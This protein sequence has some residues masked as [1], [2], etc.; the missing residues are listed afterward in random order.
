[1]KIKPSV[2][3]IWLFLFG[4]IFPIVLSAQNI[5][6]QNIYRVRVNSR[7]VLENGQRTKDF[8]AIGQLISDSLGRVHTE[9]DYDWITHYPNNYRW[10]YFTGQTKYKTDFFINEKLSRIEEYKIDENER[11]SELTVKYVS[12]NDTTF[13]VRVEYKY[14]PNGT[15]LQTKGFN[16]KGKKIYTSNH[17]YNDQGTEILRK[18]KGKS[19]IPPDSILLLSRMPMY[20]SLGRITEELLIT[21]KLSEGKSTKTIKY[22]YDTSGNLIGYIEQDEKGNQ[23]VRKEYTYRKDNRVQQ[24]KVFDAKDNLIDWQAWR[25]EIY[26]TN[27]RRQRVL[28]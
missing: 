16:A 21:N 15:I 17:K 4:I 9:I 10:H 18:L 19:I 20:D 25:Y 7:Y 11:L 8:F 14:D 26:K 1:M 22:S 27:D 3:Q 12:S 24:M 23:L 6:P 5:E 2:P 28:E 13:S